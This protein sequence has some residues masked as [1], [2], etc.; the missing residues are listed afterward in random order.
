MKAT[1]E[2]FW[3]SDNLDMI[4]YLDIDGFFFLWKEIRY[5]SFKIS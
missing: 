3:T 1:L 5:T 4:I 2:V